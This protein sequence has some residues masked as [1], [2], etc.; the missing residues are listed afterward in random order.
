MDMSRSM[1]SKE[2]LVVDDEW[3]I[4]E[5]V[6]FLLTGYG[7]QA[8][9]EADGLA[10]L[11]RLALEPVDL[12]VTDFTMPVMDGCDLLKAM[13]ENAD[14]AAIPVLVLSAMPE[15]MVRKACP[16][17]TGFL[18]KPFTSD[19]L[20]HSVSGIVGRPSPSSEPCGNAVGVGDIR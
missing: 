8:R 2:I 3:E 4:G 20:L 14:F 19:E 15:E 11:R 7:Y 17:L 9:Y 18:S 16:R 1:D 10:A 5:L 6:V 13:G 12:V